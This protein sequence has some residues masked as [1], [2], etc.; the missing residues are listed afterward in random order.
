MN[1]LF[2]TLQCDWWLVYC[3]WQILRLRVERTSLHLVRKFSVSISF[4]TFSWSRQ[5]EMRRRRNSFVF[6]LHWTERKPKCHSSESH[7]AQHW[8][9]RLFSTP[10][11]MNVLEIEARQVMSNAY[12][13]L[14]QYWTQGKRRSPPSRPGSTYWGAGLGWL[15]FMG[16]ILLLHV[17]AG[18]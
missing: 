2:Y 7:R 4:K 11:V 10:I 8:T 6:W 14:H 12:T 3:W 15:Y 18:S 5:R 16:L 9:W 1:E 13:S 17:N